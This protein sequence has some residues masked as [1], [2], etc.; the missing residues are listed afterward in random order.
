MKAC[1]LVVEY[2]PFHHGHQYH[3]EKARQVT[4][5]DV[6][7]AVMSG[8]F[9]QRGEPAIIDKWQ[10]AQAALQHGVDL[11]VELPPLGPSTLLI[12][13]HRERLGFCRICNVSCYAL[14]QIRNTPSTMPSLL[15]LKKKIN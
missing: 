9:L 12:F 1:G 13:L 3:V 14:A 2:N 6:V 5:A 11:I 15:T 4:N 10:R 8:N 7:V